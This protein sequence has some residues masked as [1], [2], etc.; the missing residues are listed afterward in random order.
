MMD[1]IKASFEDLLCQYPSGMSVNSL[2]AAK[3]FGIKQ[4][5]IVPGNGAAELIK[6]L[7]ENHCGRLGNII[8]TFEEYPNRLQADKIV[9]FKIQS[10]DFHYSADDIM[11]FF[12]GK[13]IDT[14]LLINPDNPS[15][16]YI[17]YV[18]ILRLAEWCKERSIR[19]VVDESFV[20]FTDV[21]G[22]TSLLDNNVLE[23]HPELVVVKSISKSF[24][25]PGIRLG[26]LASSDLSL[27]SAIKKDVSIWNINSFG[28]FFLQIYEKYS[29]EYKTACKRFMEERKRFHD[30]LL[31][32]PYLEVLPS[33]ANY[34]LCR[35]TDRFNSHG[36]AV[37]L[38]K[39]KI[40][41]KDCGG[42]KGFDNSNFIRLAIRDRKDNDKL[43]EALKT[44]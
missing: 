43:I 9:Q 22:R 10:D 31:T 23:K 8:P 26:I 12:D 27:I 13:K 14:L 11:S 42:K 30:M 32:I 35:V 18:D 4:D 28:E 33:Q 7:M 29:G 1:E 19:L 40:F 24:G 15:G 3:N 17:P 37:E 25:V 34:F 20:D 44:I 16:N 38:L 39:H 6:S 36:L 41:I 5:F 2:L 21:E